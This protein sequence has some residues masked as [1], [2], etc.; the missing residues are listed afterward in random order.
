[1]TRYVLDTNVLTD[2]IS[3][4][5]NTLK[6]FENAV[7]SGHQLLLSSPVYYELKRGLLHKQATKSLHYLE[8]NLR[9][10]MDFVPVENDDWQRS[11]EWWVMLR[12]NGKQ[13]SDMDLLIGAIT[14]RLSVTLVTADEDFE[15]LPILRVNWRAAL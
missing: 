2:I 6:N 9:V 13:L 10:L 14:K 3:V 11:A 15:A 4:Q 5:P 1:M 8:N 12:K 7:L